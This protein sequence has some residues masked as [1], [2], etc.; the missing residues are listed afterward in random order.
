[1]VGENMLNSVL[2]QNTIIATCSGRLR[3]YLSLMGPKMSW[4]SARP[5]MLNDKPICTI[6]IDV[7]KKS[8]IDGRLGRYMSVTKG[9]NADIKPKNM[10][11]NTLY[12]IVVVVVLFVV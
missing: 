1:M 3:P 7:S 9:P 2:M 5:I 10:S 8:T 6:E 11:R 4:P 12:F